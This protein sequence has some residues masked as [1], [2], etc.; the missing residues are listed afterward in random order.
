M[1]AWLDLP[2]GIHDRV[3]E[4]RQ[5]AS[6]VEVSPGVE[7]AP[8]VGRDGAPATAQHPAAPDYEAHEAPPRAEVPRCAGTGDDTVRDRWQGHGDEDYG[9]PQPGDADSV[10]VEP[11]T[12]C[13]VERV[14]E[15][16]LVLYLLVTVPPEQ[17]GDARVDS[18]EQLRPREDRVADL[19]E[20]VLARHGDRG[21]EI[22][23]G[24]IHDREPSQHG[25]RNGLDRN[26][27][28]DEQPVEGRVHAGV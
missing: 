13:R 7:I 19:A 28:P 21:S 1:G 12:A 2:C 18:L 14:E 6:V 16:C 10:G 26:T 22:A 15:H 8:M 25:I 17:L 4:L 27:P 20:E 9:D 5:E 24:P 11:V 3:V 23:R